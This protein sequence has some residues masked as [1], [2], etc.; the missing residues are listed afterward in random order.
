MALMDLIGTPG[1]G[2]VAV[3][4]LTTVSKQF[5]S[6]TIRMQ[7]FKMDKDALKK[8]MASESVVWTQRTQLN[9]AEYAPILFAMLMFMHVLKVSGP[10]C[11][12]VSIAA[13]LSQF[14]YFYG[15]VATGQLL[16]FTPMGALPRY[17]SMLAGM[18]L[19]YGAL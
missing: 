1:F 5:M 17:A 11:T 9:E 19:I 18:Y 7:P 16:P 15:R 8:Y 14:V 10:L 2:A 12:A 6:F 13:P 4:V 3:G